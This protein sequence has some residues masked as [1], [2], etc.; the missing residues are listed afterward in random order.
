MYVAMDEEFSYRFRSVDACNMCTAPTKGAAVLGRRLSAHQGVRPTRAVGIAT[1]VQRCGACGLVFSNPMPVPL[2]IAQHYGTPPDEYWREQYFDVDPEGYF[3]SQIERFRLLWGRS[4]HPRALDIGA[5]I[6]KAMLSMD[7]AGFDAYG[8]EPSE[9][10][11]ERAV[12]KAGIDP[13]RLQLASVET[14]AYPTHSFDF[15]SFGAVLEHLYDPAASIEKA[16]TWLAPGGLVHIE[17]PSSRWLTSRLGNLAYRL[18]GLDYSAN[19][20]PMHVPYH[21]YEF[22]REAFEAHARRAGYRVAGHRFYVGETFLPGFST[23]SA[24]G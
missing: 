23:R 6:G 21:L 14:A 24:R 11:H 13:D 9:P 12:S 4:G 22:T 16:F 17:V 15:V 1:T 20:S 2:E 19:I 18:Q 3:V 7:R 10:F 5:G 8:L